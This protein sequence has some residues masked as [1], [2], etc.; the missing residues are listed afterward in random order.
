MK[1]NLEKL[2]DTIFFE[3]A[4]EKTHHIM[5]MHKGDN[6]RIAYSGGSDSD[7]MMWFM[8]LLGYNIP[9]VFYNSGL[10]YLATKNH[11]KDMRNNGF[12]I[13][14]IKPKYYI[15]YAMRKYGIPFINKNTSDMVGRLQKHNFDFINDG[16]KSFEEL[17][18]KY[19]NSATAL[20]WWTNSFISKRFN[21]SWN[22]NLKEFLI[23]N[24]GV[25]FS[26][27]AKC[28]EIIK[29]N[30]MKEYAKK[31]DIKLVLIGLRKA[32][33]GRRSL[34]QNCYVPPKENAYSKYYPL[35]WWND[36]EK[37]YFNTLFEIQNSDC[38]TKYGLTRTGCA[39]CPYGL[40]FEKEL[41]ILKTFEPK[42]Y[43]LATHIFKNSY[44]A[45][46]DYHKFMKEHR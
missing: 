22:K 38:Y 7:T 28:C 15:P 9:A 14:E 34:F 19:S 20:K 31:N 35:F 36:E 42:L 25:P 37:K 16:D 26:V 23:Q 21:I 43:K 6:V 41:E 2:K 46:L 5:E 24:N 30:T 29:K 8:K 3:Q 44:R 11:I 12:I 45:T 18:E 10:E 39:G 1:M 33:G 32:E 13:E 17:S 4:A 40:H 27:S